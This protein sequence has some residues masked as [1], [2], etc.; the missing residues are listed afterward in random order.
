MGWDQLHAIELA[1]ISDILQH[2]EKS[3]QK[4]NEAPL[5]IPGGALTMQR[6]QRCGQ[7]IIIPTMIQLNKLLGIIVVIAKA[8]QCTTRDTSASPSGSALLCPKA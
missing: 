4:K 3:M 5:G 1:V 7:K 6:G 2:M 8:V